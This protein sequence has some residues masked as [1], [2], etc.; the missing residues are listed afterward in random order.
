MGT[1]VCFVFLG[2]LTEEA[3]AGRFIFGLL[4]LQLLSSRFL[5]R[6]KMYGA[7]HIY[8]VFAKKTESVCFPFCGVGLFY[9]QAD[10]A[11]RAVHALH[12]HALN[13]GRF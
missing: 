3:G 13:V 4:I 5:R 6:Y 8:H 2:C 1:V 10:L 11:A 12:E 7:I 9:N